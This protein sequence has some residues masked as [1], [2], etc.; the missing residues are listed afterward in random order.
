MFTVCNLCKFPEIGPGFIRNCFWFL[1]EVKNYY[2]Y[3]EKV[4]IV[5]LL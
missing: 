5:F 3:V 2:Q 4:F 1:T